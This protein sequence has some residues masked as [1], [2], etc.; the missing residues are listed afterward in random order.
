MISPSMYDLVIQET[1]CLLKETPHINDLGIVYKPITSPLE[2]NV[3]GFEI[4]SS[5]YKKISA[6]LQLKASCKGIPPEEISATLLDR[7]IRF[8]MEILM[9]SQIGQQHSLGVPL[10]VSV[11]APLLLNESF[12]M[13]LKPFLTSYKQ[14]NSLFLLIEID[15]ETRFPRLFNWLNESGLIRTRHCLLKWRYSSDGASS[16]YFHQHFSR[17]SGL[18]LAA[19]RIQS[20][21]E[22]EFVLSQQIPYVMGSYISAPQRDINRLSSLPADLMKVPENKTSAVPGVRHQSFAPAMP[23][24]GRITS[25]TAVLTFQ[26]TGSQAKDLFAANPLLEGIVVI[27]EDDT[28]LG[29]VMREQ[30]YRNLSRQYG[31]EIFMS[32][33]IAL[34]MVPTPLVV[35]AQTPIDEVGEMAMRRSQERLY[36]YV[37]VQKEGR[38]HGV[39]SIRELLINISEMNVNIAKYA[40]P[41]T[42]LPGNKLI[43]ERISQA[44][45]LDT[46][47]LLYLDLNHF[48]AYNDLY[49]FKKGDEMLRALGNI[50]QKSLLLNNE[51]DGFLGH[52]GG[53]DFVILLTH[54]RYESLCRQII[55]EFDA[56]I[57]L[58]Y[59]SSDL[60]RGYLIAKNRNNQ[61]ERTPL[62][63]LSITAITNELFQ[64]N[65]MDHLTMAAA[66]GKKICKQTTGSHLHALTLQQWKDVMIAL[67]QDDDTLHETQLPRSRPIL[68]TLPG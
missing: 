41:L 23:P 49:G 55:Q 16:L 37:V 62:V 27:S 31:Y 1:G 67:K 29:L 68:L 56:A 7:Q 47:T 24:V 18:P 9:A 19:I 45:Q 44:L 4:G 11:P 13:Y 15:E 30:F 58:F 21:E 10:Y 6:H 32:R 17:W 8:L 54:Y 34:I 12:M 61:D 26:S 5:Q 40:N 39:V 36:D 3:C 14:V 48:K 38:Y 59:R 65:S 64:F 60:Q 53:D 42:G 35:A 2:G 43:D 22:Y 28:A 33:P 66:L 57:S 25:T 50:L 63:S 46:C 51:M 52:I 20:R